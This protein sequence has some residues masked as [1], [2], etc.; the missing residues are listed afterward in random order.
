[1][2]DDFLLTPDEQ[3]PQVCSEKQRFRIHVP[4][5]KTTAS[6]GAEAPGGKIREADTGAPNYAGFGVDT[7]GHV[8]ISARGKGAAENKLKLQSLGEMT[9]LTESS[10]MMGSK[11]SALLATPQTAMVTGNEGVFIA[12]GTFLPAAPIEVPKGEA[13]PDHPAYLD[14]VA[15]AVTQVSNMWSYVDT[16]FAALEI[17]MVATDTILTIRETK[18]F[19]PLKASLRALFDVYMANW[20]GNVSGLAG[21]DHPITFG[22]K[23]NTIIHGEGGLILG[24]MGSAGLFSAI[25]T[26][27]GSAVGVGITA[28][29]ASVLSAFDTSVK[30][31]LGGTSVSAKKSLELVG[32]DGV[33][34][35]ART[36]S[37]AIR[38]TQIILGSK[39]GGDKQLEAAAIGIYGK[40][41]GVAAKEELRLTG[42][43]SLALN[44]KKSALGGDVVSIGGQKKVGIAAKNVA[45]RGTDAVAI[46]AEGF[47]VNVGK[48]GIMIGKAKKN[49]PKEPTW[50][51]PR[52]Q[53]ALAALASDT[54]MRDMAP[55]KAEIAKARGEFED[56]WYAWVEKCEALQAKDS[57]IE[58]KD[59][60]ISLKVKSSKLEIDSGKLQAMKALIVK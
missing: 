28:P 12:G 35:A 10:L 17:A 27:I 6:F 29:I 24:S 52:E 45:I 32:G 26:T 53:E 56:K 47:C 25:G 11:Q 1:M 40:G 48:S 23:G 55:Y 44:A 16:A 54:P 43:K 33:E 18:K 19:P 31:A 15:G 3:A 2:E 30:S 42:G 7:E 22:A 36:G 14:G 13:A 58:I 4:N 59:A 20:G 38:G 8:F 5:V 34:M 9:F 60:K 50:K 41:V 57:V 39:A 21:V 49:F 51:N 46:G 37:V